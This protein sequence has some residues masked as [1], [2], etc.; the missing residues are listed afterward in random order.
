MKY[1]LLCLSIL[2]LSFGKGQAQDAPK[3]KTKIHLGYALFMNYNLYSW[4][5]KPST[6]ETPLSSSGQV[7]NVLPGLGVNFWVG[8]VDHWIVSLEA[9]MEYL[10]FAFDTDRYKGLGALSIPVLAKVQ[11]PVAKQKSLWLMLHVGAGAQFLHTDIYARPD[12]YL[13]AVNPFFT[14]IVG[15][16]GLHLSAI[17]RKRQHI[18]EAELFF[19]AGGAPLGAASFTTGL[20]LTFWNRFGK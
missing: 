5:Q 19:R 11:F 3:T 8:D 16:V 7:L 20:R 14:T 17:G 2:G 9:G 10:P 4:Y 18:R 12:A 1:I 6:I 15:E 13:N